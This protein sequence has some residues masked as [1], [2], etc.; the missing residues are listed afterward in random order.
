[1]MEFIKDNKIAVGAA[2]LIL[3]LGI[4]AMVMMGGSTNNVS[5]NAKVDNSK[6][7]SAKGNVGGDDVSGNTVGGD[8]NFDKSSGKE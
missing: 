6:S 4:V 8:F 3:A 5:G 2:A 7:V 1:M